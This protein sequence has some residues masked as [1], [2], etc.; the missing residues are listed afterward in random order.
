M[1]YPIFKLPA[2][3]GPLDYVRS[4]ENA[5]RQVCAELG[6]AKTICLPGKTG[7][8]IQDEKTQRAN[9]LIAI[10]VGISKGVTRH[11]FAFNV[12]TNLSRFTKHIIPCGLIDHGVTSLQRELPGKYL[13]SIEK[14]SQQVANTLQN[15]SV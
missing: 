3:K 8:W 14:L 6:I 12:T 15:F 1:G 9:K 11:G 10:G 5:L 13:P 4:L 7:V 2:S